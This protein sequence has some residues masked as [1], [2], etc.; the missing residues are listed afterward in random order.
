MSPGLA[1]AIFAGIAGIAGAYLLG[2]I[3]FSVLIVK[4]VQGLDVRRVGSG[5]AGATNALRAAGRK[6]GVAVL[7]LDVAKG[8]TAVAVPR[9]LD[10]PPAVVGGAAVAVVVGHVFPVF[11]GFRGGKGVATSLGA[12]GTLS[13]ACMALALVVF[14]AVLA[15]RRYVSLA[16][17]VTAAVFPLLVWVE[18]RL[19]WR[20]SGG[21]WLLLAS[22]AIALLIVAR[23]ITNLRRLRNGTE[24]RLGE[25]RRAP[26]GEGGS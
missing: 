6:A 17:I 5:N 2:S 20:E 8:V 19:H 21:L 12:L 13:P 16:S 7:A 25:P 15:W 3:S 11:F 26:A 10:A 22:T 23:H 24:P 9:A 1:A 4:L 18:L 14:L